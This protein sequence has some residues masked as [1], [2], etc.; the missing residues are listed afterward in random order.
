MKKRLMQGVYFC[1]DFGKRIAEQDVMGLSAEMSYHFVLSI[2]PFIIFLVATAGFLASPQLVTSMIDRAASFLPGDAGAAFS[3]PMR[4]ILTTRRPGLLSVGAIGALWTASGGI[5]TIMKGLNA[6]H[7]VKENR[8]FFVKTL[9][10]LG[11][12]LFLAAAI[13]LGTAVIIGAG[14]VATGLAIAG[15]PGWVRLAAGIG[16]PVAAF[17]LWVLTVAVIYWKAPAL[18]KHPF[19]LITPGALVFA[20]GWIGGTLLFGWYVSNFASYNRVYGSIAGIIIL[21]IWAFWS[22]FLLL[23]GGMINALVEERRKARRP[24]RRDEQGREEQPEEEQPVH[25]LRRSG[26]QRRA[27]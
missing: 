23:A 10:K 1:R 3:G 8:S 2:F 11:L 5:Q 4:D 25:E 16:G 24:L 22:G 9:V 15:L 7:L 20:L 18:K 19:K 21:M 17:C 13:L 27:A 14:A 6:A 12:T 26:G